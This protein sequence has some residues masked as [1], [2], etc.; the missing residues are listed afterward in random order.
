MKDYDSKDLVF[1]LIAPTGVNLELFQKKF[2]QCLKAYNY[3]VIPIQVTRILEEFYSDEIPT[4]RLYEKVKKKIELGT[5]LRSDCKDNEILAKYAAVKI[6]EERQAC[7]ESRSRGKAFIIRQLKRPEE[8]DFLAR[9]YGSLFF[10]IGV[11]APETER[12]KNILRDCEVTGKDSQIQKAKELFRLDENEA[13][14]SWGQRMEKTFHRSDVFFDEKDNEDSIF[15]FLDLVFKSPYIAPSKDELFMNM[16][17]MASL[18]SIDLSRQ[19]GAVIVSPTDEVIA[20]GS[21]DVP[22]FGGGQYWPD[23]DIGTDIHRGKDANKEE[24]AKLME[25]ILG[26]IRT[27]SIEI[28]NR[29]GEKLDTTRLADLTE[30]MRAV[31]AEMEAILSCARQGKSVKDAR[32]YC[33]TFPCH[34]CAKHLVGAGI[35]RVIYVEP[36]PKSLALELHS[37]S[38]AQGHSEV[39]TVFQQFTGIGPNR[40]TDLF[41]VKLSKGEPIKR[42]D[43]DGKAIQFERNS[44][45]PKF[46]FNDMELEYIRKQEAM[47]ATEIKRAKELVNGKNEQKEDQTK[48]SSAK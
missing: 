38:I 25:D 11:L 28:A 4:A 46:S 19:V 30:F 17:F 39:H 21:N 44:A 48:Q 13:S 33:T 31:H 18:K 37:D 1:A 3:D 5:R 32:L 26:L 12:I 40:F 23:G 47:A 45:S 34:N 36:Y 24:I 35:R 14:D 27:E 9:I 7:L 41:S 43:G 29:I 15:R 22:K 8:L 6:S 2:E 10:S 42:K 20:M 16:A